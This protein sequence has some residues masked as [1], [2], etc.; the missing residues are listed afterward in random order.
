LPWGDA[1]SKPLAECAAVIIRGNAA[2]VTGAA[3]AAIV[4]FSRT[5]AT[6]TE[7]NGGLPK[8]LFGRTAAMAE[9]G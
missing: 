3:E 9:R 2:S 5:L 8:K 7:R 4:G 1:I 6:G